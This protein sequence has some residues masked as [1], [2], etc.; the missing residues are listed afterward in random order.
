MSINARG[1]AQATAR[2]VALMTVSDAECMRR[3][4]LHIVPLPACPPLWL[5]CQGHAAGPAHPHPPAAASCSATA[6]GARNPRRRHGDDRTRSLPTESIPASMRC[7]G[8]AVDASLFLR[9]DVVGRAGAAMRVRLSQNSR[10]LENANELT[11]RVFSSKIRVRVIG[12]SARW[13]QFSRSH[14]RQ[15][16]PTGVPSALSKSTPAA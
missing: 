10:A 14:R 8:G 6:G 11:R 12:G 2:R 1:G 7:G 3:F 16:T 5:S 13:L 4:L 9:N 15:L